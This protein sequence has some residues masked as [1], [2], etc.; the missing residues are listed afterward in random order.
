MYA[1]RMANRRFRRSLVGYRRREVDDALDASERALA[2]ARAATEA[3][4]RE[5]KSRERELG[6]QRQQIDELDRVAIVLAERV[7]GHRKELESLRA[8]LAER[9]DQASDRAVRGDLRLAG[10]EP[11]GE[12]GE[13]VGEGRDGVLGPAGELHPRKPGKRFV[14]QDSQ[15]EAR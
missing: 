7:V 11:D 4:H 1:V 6:W 12:G 5:L 3:R 13:L 10:Q 14:E 8:E 9:R 2:E 15:L